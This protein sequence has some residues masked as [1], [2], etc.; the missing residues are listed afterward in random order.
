MISVIVVVDV[1]QQQAGVRPVHN[2]PNVEAHAD[3]PEVGIF[4]LVNLVKLQRRMSRVQLEIEGRGLD[5]FLL[6]AAEPGEAV[7]ERVGDTEFHL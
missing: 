5:S 4:R 3:R 6:V 7:R 1:A 2:Q